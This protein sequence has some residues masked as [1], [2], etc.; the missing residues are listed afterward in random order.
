MLRVRFH[1]R[2]VDRR[3][4][5][6]S[7]VF[8]VITAALA[9]AFIGLNHEMEALVLSPA[10]AWFA[11][12]TFAPDEAEDRKYVLTLGGLSKTST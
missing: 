11:F 3:M 12:L 9:V 6:S 4:S 5:V 8:T 1:G 2:R 10:A 7:L